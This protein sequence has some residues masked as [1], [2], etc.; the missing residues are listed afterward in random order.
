MTNLSSTYLTQSLKGADHFAVS[1]RF[2]KYKLAISLGDMGRRR[3]L[4]RFMFGVAFLLDG[5][6]SS[7]QPGVRSAVYHLLTISSPNM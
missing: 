7:P 2:S 6:L 3:P 1:S 4:C 5:F